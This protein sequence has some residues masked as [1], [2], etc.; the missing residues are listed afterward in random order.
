MPGDKAAQHWVGIAWHT[1]AIFEDGRSEPVFCRL[2][3]TDDSFAAVFDFAVTA[4]GYI[5]YPL[6]RFDFTGNKLV[7]IDP[8][9]PSEE[10]LVIDL[11]DKPPS[12]FNV[13]ADDK[14][15]YVLLKYS[16]TESELMRL[17]LEHPEYRESLTLPY[18][19][20]GWGSVMAMIS[21]QRGNLLVIRL[22]E[23]IA[24]VDRDSFEVIDSLKDRRLF[25]PIVY[26]PSQQA[27][28]MLVMAPPVSSSR[29]RTPNAPTDTTGLKVY[30]HPKL[31]IEE[32]AIAQ[33]PREYLDQHGIFLSNGTCDLDRTGNLAVAIIGFGDKL[34]VLDLRT[35]EW[36]SIHV[37]PEKQEMGDVANLGDDRFAIGGNLIYD[38]NTDRLVV[39]EG[40][41][42]TK[43]VQ[44][45]PLPNQ[46]ASYG[47]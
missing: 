21:G 6:S 34:A 14:W 11:G 15:L 18:D 36:M 37:L 23:G 46:S 41:L 28:I 8:L 26:S 32:F 29:L 17:S 44:I 39:P 16:L 27:L 25:G 45:K 22:F 1:L 10:A 47:D 13:I 42:F 43:F 38:L 2:P 35:N 20:G 7:R 40:D 31:A 3:E 12:P 19:G 33:P 9:N 4:D 5:W 24:I 30:I